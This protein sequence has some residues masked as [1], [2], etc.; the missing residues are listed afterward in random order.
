LALLG[1]SGDDP[2]FL[3]WTG[4]IR[5]ELGRNHAPIYLVGPLPLGTAK[6]SLLER[7]G[8]T[9]IDLSPLWPANRTGDIHAG[10]IQEF[11]EALYD[12]QPA[13]K[14]KWPDVSGPKSDLGRLI[15]AGPAPPA[16]V[17]PDPPLPLTAE[18]AGRVVERWTFE[19]N[20]YPGWVVAPED[21]RSSLWQQTKDWFR[22]L[23]KFAEDCPAADRILLF[24]EINWRLD[25]VMAPSFMEL[26]GPFGKALDEILPDLMGGRRSFAAS[27]AGP[28]AEISGTEV[29]DAWLE[30]AFG[31][32]RDAREDYDAARWR[33]WKRKIDTVI[34]L[35]PKPSDRNQYETALWEIWNVERE[36]AKSVLAMWQ[37]SSYSP[38][39]AMRKAALLAE[40]DELG[41]AR[42]LL[43]TALL[44]IRRALRNQGQNIELLSM[45]GWC[46]YLL[47]AAERSL[48]AAAFDTASYDALR[49]E[50]GE[51]WEELKAWDCDPRPHKRYFDEALSAESRVPQKIQEEV[52]GFDPGEV[53]VTTHLSGGDATPYLP[54]FACIRLYEQVGIPMRLPGVKVVG[55]ALRNACR[56][57]APFTG[58]WSPALLIRAGRPKDLTHG[59]FLTRTQARNMDS[60]LASRVYVWC[61]GILQRELP[62]VGQIAMGS[63]RESLLEA[64][65]EVLSRLAFKADAQ[66]LRKTFPLAFRFHKLPAV[67]AH[68]GVVN[69]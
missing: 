55:D 11:L 24:R 25:T 62:L 39:A 13:R 32:F 58:F 64:L 34:S 43:R 57:L 51:R 42:S 18:V 61:L 12:A 46:T 20:E 22:P 52:L 65:I 60:A 63:A 41:E 50:F 53:T 54:G 4:W 8:V 17:R 1:F 48:C 31:L 2:N 28:P 45:D 19:R 9:L 49:D 23:A 21:K 10:T 69:K 16:E 33:E 29:A 3:E 30:I 7:R 36:Q 68:L 66:D 5:D 27:Q 6:R 15:A 44:E 26:V 59:S 40:L 14:W 35:Q 37:P 38:L 56:W 67:R 47:G